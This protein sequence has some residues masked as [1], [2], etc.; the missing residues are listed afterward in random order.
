MGMG[1]LAI[2]ALSVHAGCLW[3]FHVDEAMR[4]RRTSES[5]LHEMTSDLALGVQRAKVS[6]Y[7]GSLGVVV[8]CER[9]RVWAG[10]K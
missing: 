9:E 7:F 2:R 10:H 6:Q 1:K 3:P 8:K 4:T 5:W